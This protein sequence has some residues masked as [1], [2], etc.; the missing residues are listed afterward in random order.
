[1]ETGVQN[2]QETPAGS[3]YGAA[4]CGRRALTILFGGWLLWHRAMAADA[5]PPVRLMFSQSIVSGANLNDARVAMQVWIKQMSVDYS[6][7]VELSPKVFDT[8]EE[9]VRRARNGQLDAVALNLIEY[10]RI[11][12]ML[13]FSQVVTDGGQVQYLLLAKK[14]SGAHLSNLRGAG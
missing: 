8:S 7:P 13:D 2:G 1:M 3:D 10:R 6:L 12:D 4:S 11:A 5:A 9:I 14:A